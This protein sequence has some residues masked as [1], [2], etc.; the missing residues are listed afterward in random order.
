MRRRTFLQTAGAVLVASAV[1]AAQ[2]RGGA[3]A[4]DAFEKS[5]REL[6]ADM[7]S[8]A[9]TSVAL[10]RFYLRRI[11]AFDQAVRG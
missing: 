11:A 5:L 8:G 2:A 7:A 10:V 4:Y 6:Q 3:A 1:P 9:T